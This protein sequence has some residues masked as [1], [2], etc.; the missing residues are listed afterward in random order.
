MKSTTLRSRLVRSEREDHSPTLAISKQTPI[1]STV[2]SQVEEEEESIIPKVMQA[3]EV[4]ADIDIPNN[5]GWPIAISKG[6]R[7]C[8]KT[9][10]YPISNYVSYS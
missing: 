4:L 7:E 9:K 3:E 8:K 1:I 10:L 6:V 2:P 5:N